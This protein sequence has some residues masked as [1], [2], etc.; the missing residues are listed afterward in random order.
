MKL[1][2]RAV[3]MSVLAGLGYLAYLGLPDMKRYWRM[4][5]M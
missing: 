5:Q 2:R 3:A 4:R 1:I